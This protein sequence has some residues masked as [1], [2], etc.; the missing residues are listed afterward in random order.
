MTMPLD[1]AGAPPPVTPAD[2]ASSPSNYAN[3]FPHGQGPAP[4]DILAP[5]QDLSGLVT[6]AGNLSGGAEGGTT[7]AGGLYGTGPR[8]AATEVLLSSGAGFG[9]YDI[10]IGYA[11]GGGSWP[12]DIEP[13]ES[14][15]V[16][17]GTD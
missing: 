15:T 6:A 2:T 11:G 17:T 10:Q 14:Y 8:Q 13:P 3:V 1:P 5:L 4:Y 7:G 9:E 12:A 16:A